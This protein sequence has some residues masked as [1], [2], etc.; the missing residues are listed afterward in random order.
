[1][2]WGWSILVS[3]QVATKQRKIGIVKFYQKN[4]N[5]FFL[6]YFQFGDV[7]DYCVVEI[8]AWILEVACCEFSSKFP[9][10]H[11]TV[12]T[13]CSKSEA[14]HSIYWSLGKSPLFFL[15]HFGLSDFVSVI[16]R[17]QKGLKKGDYL[18]KCP[19]PL[20]KFPEINS[21]ITWSHESVMMHFMSQTIGCIQFKW[22][23]VKEWTLRKIRNMRLP[24]FKLLSQLHS[25]QTI[26]VMQFV[27][28]IVIK[29]YQ[30]AL[31]DKNVNWV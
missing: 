25:R 11:L 7:L 4:K 10:L 3:C 28:V 18:E 9:P 15:W 26:W 21:C 29:N 16:I 14:T 27:I 17:A 12:W 8:R 1:M 13:V 31:K 24:I 6:Q 2:A 30:K 5:Y 20:Y 22:S 23:K 19:G